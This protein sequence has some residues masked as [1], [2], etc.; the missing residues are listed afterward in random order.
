MS[1]LKIT[2]RRSQNRCE[3]SRIISH[4]DCHL[5]R[6]LPLSSHSQLLTLGYTNAYSDLHGYSL[7]RTAPTSALK[8]MLFFILL[9]VIMPFSSFQLLVQLIW[10]FIF[11]FIAS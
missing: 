6:W 3:L 5:S 7:P 10:L 11:S 4:Q 1:R 8:P 9:F 2:L